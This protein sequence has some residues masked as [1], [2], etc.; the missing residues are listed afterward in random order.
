MRRLA[1]DRGIGRGSAGSRHRRDRARLR[2][3]VQPDR[4]QL[5][6]LRRNLALALDTGKPAI[7][8]CRSAD[9]RRDAQDALVAELGR[10]GRAARRGAQRSA[11]GRRRSST[12]SRAPTLARTV[13]DLGLAVSFSGLVFRRGGPLGNWWWLPFPLLVQVGLAKTDK[14]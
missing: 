12:R 2:P 6:D 1:G 5:A 4:G 14:Q 9:G 10:P 7:L 8:H 13:V 3:C 11:T